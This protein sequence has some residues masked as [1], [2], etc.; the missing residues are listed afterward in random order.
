[1]EAVKIHHCIKRFHVWIAENR[2][3]KKTSTSM[4][5]NCADIKNRAERDWIGIMKKMKKEE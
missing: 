5:I 3:N 4:Q 2:I 1:M